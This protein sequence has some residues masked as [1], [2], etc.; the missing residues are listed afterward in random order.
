MCTME[1]R[2]EIM[3]WY[4]KNFAENEDVLL[5]GYHD[6]KGCR[7][8]F[9]RLFNLA[10]CYDLEEFADDVFH[11]LKGWARG[12]AD[13]TCTTPEGLWNYCMKSNGGYTFGA[14]FEIYTRNPATWQFERTY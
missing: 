6:R 7:E 9:S 14:I 1:L 11:M 4:L 13:K 10:E 5:I 2:E 8:R 3:N 12:N